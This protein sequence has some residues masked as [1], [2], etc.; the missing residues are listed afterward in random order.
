MSDAT[1]RAPRVPSAL[2]MLM[3]GIVAIAAA[4]LVDGIAYRYIAI[5]G[6]YDEDWGR[7]LRVMGFAPLWLVVAIALVLH[8]APYA[9]LSRWTR[10]ARG[11]LLVAGV[12]AA[13]ILGEL[14]KLLLRRE[15]PRA[16]EGEYVFR[17]FT[18]RPF[19]SGGLAWPSSHAIVAFGAAAVLSR[20]FPRARWVFWGLAWGCGLSRVADGAHFVSDVVTAA[21]AAWLVV[22]QIW[23]WHARRRAET[24]ALLSRPAAV[25]ARSIPA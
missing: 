17:S 10:W 21:V 11:A 22:D 1:E 15:R 25:P 20:L 16:H 6:I 19:S 12:A 13:G 5:D 7:M 9:V 8:D 23:R 18:E 14:L 2:R 4:H 3:F 24:H